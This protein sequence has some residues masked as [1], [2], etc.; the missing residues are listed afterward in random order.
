MSNVIGEPLESYV[1][2]QINVRQNLHGSGVND[3]TR[4]DI[5]IN[6]LNSNTSWIK[7][8]SGVSIN[9]S[10]LEDIGFSKSQQELYDGMG[11]AKNNILFGGTANLDI[12]NVETDKGIK[13]Y[14]IL[15]QRDGFNPRSINSSYTYSEF[16]FSP[17]AGIESA[18]VK[19]LNR[20]SLKKA[21]V[22]LKAN[23]KKQ[24]DIID[25]LYLRLGYTV[26]LEWGNTF[27]SRNGINKIIIRNTLMEEMFFD[28][29]EKGSYLDLLDNIEDK[30]NEYAG[31]YDG[32]FGKVSNFSWSFNT[33][34]TYDIELTIISLGDVIESL[35]T[36]ISVDK[37]TFEFISSNKS[38]SSTT[39]NSETEQP[40]DPQII[41][42]NKDTDII[43]AMLYA[44]KFLNQPSKPTPFGLSLPS[45]DSYKPKVQIITPDKKDEPYNVGNLL[46]NTQKGGD[47]DTITS[48]EYVIEF[49]IEYWIRTGR[50][51]KSTSLPEIKKIVEILDPGKI[52]SQKE[53]EEEKYI[54]D[55]KKFRKKYIKIGI[56]EKPPIIK[57]KIINKN[58]QEIT[59]PLKDAPYGSA[60]VLNTKDP[61]YYLR[62]GYLL[63]YIK[64]NILPRIVIGNKH[65][66]NPPIFDI[67]I[68]SWDNYMYSLPN[69]ISV[70]PKVCIVRNNNFDGGNGIIR[71][72]KGLNRFREA[73]GGADEN[74]YSALPLNI[75][76]NFNFITECL[77]KD[78]RGDV[79]LYEFISSICT[80]LNKA[81]GGINN[82]EPIINE[83]TNTLKII[84]TTPIPGRSGG[85]PN[86]PYLLQL[87]GYDKTTN[88]YISNFI[89]K[90]D[91]KTVI[92]PGFATMITVGA[93]A[94]G[95]VKG[96]EATAFSKWNTGLRDRYKENFE[97]GNLASV[98][99]TGEID[100]AEVNYVNEFLSSNAY[101]SRYGFDHLPPYQFNLVD[102]TIQKNISVVTEYY[103]YLLSKNKADSG[104][105]IGFIPF[106]LS[107][108]MDGLS[109]IKIYNKLE[110]NT[111]F[112]PKAYGKNNNLI[113]TGVTHKLSNND[114]ETAIEATLMPKSSKLSGIETSYNP[115]QNSID[116]VN[117]NPPP[118]SS[119]AE[120]DKIVYLMN[121]LIN[122][123][124]FSIFQ[125]AA[126]AGN[127]KIESGGFKEWNIENGKE[128]KYLNSGIGLM[129]WT[130]VGGKRNGRY[131]FE[132]F[133][134]KWLTTN[135]VITPYVKN[136]IL[137]TN[138]NNYNKG[139][140]LEAA[141]KSIPKL[142]EAEAAYVLTFIKNRPNVITNFNAAFNGTKNIKGNSHN[143]IKNKYF[144]YVEN[145]KVKKDIG[146]FTELFLIDA[147]TPKVVLDIYDN[148]D[149]SKSEVQKYRNELD[150]RVDS[151]LY[152]LGVYN[153]SK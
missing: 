19:T 21:T 67:D 70:D 53:F 149:A 66:D 13:S 50:A 115:I 59:N 132:K 55:V 72:F 107:F 145:G 136:F 9:K 128:A 137:D 51:S 37:A 108:T 3:T 102:D 48:T 33:D 80:G 20:G 83:N 91:V 86:T 43:S 1:A 23:D 76:L 77:K 64:D 139:K 81:L 75:Y 116:N 110:V 30:R 29:T 97:P 6:L 104:G 10:R 39:T 103:K 78:D 7:L 68:D 112:L 119:P 14:D 56:D 5:Q 28:K 124:N 151:S 125:A 96:T 85:I 95:Y 99:K 152:C 114:W 27:Y 73:D 126:V 11:L 74:Q 52:Y 42:S 89:R 71:I 120:N 121:L 106:K 153:K 69:Q 122:Q 18:E 129:Q 54:E 90:V 8:G 94:G 61:N 44:W 101:V 133:V 4:T 47:G 109:G 25:L 22:K 36:N 111:E 24:F 46:F 40:T 26:L 100:E 113:I 32:L 58:N 92:D 35:K 45:Y 65:D 150:K 141:L 2:E 31:N 118:T 142:F 117:N 38:I 98:K 17:M 16:G 105:T 147:E 62:F 15:K 63:K 12:N 88:G 131:N 49:S 138:P 148:S 144:K 57:Y 41:E 93:T 130:D 135:A 82:L 34:G 140:S 127:I 134:G 60:F 87:Y 123:L 79:N 143:M 84:D 146:G